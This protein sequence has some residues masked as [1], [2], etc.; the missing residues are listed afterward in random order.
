MYNNGTI[1]LDGKVV[2]ING[3][4]GEVATVEL[5][6]NRVHTSVEGVLG[7]V[8]HDIEGNTYGFI[9]TMGEVH[10]LDTSLCPEGGALYV[11]QDGALTHTRPIAPNFVI[12]VATCIYSHVTNGKILVNVNG[13]PQDIIEN[14]FNGS[15]IEGMKF[16]VT[17]DGTT[18]TGTLQLNGGGDLTAMFSD[19]FTTIDCTPAK[20]IILTAGTATIPQTNWVYLLKS[21]KDITTSTSG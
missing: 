15:F 6:D 5:A 4:F 9:T 7:V 21:T 8:T 11:G 12:Q 17:S 20:T 18:I 14:A 10:E 16:T 2:R 1:K 19:G 3:S 13:R